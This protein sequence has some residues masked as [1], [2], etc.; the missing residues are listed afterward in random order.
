ME[1]GSP[2][3]FG[4]ARPTGKLSVNVLS[5]QGMTVEFTD[6]P[7]YLPNTLIFPV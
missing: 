1:K 4:S 2:I 7:Q 3:G 6:P 5:A